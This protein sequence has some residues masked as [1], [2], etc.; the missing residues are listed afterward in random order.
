MKQELTAENKTRSNCINRSAYILY[1]ML[2]VF[3]LL[4]GDYE[5][6]VANMGIA[7]VFDPFA[8]AEWQHRTKPQKVCLFIHLTLLFAGAAFLCFR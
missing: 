3:Q 6:A 7:L 5:S 4:T 8:P 1:M 2:V